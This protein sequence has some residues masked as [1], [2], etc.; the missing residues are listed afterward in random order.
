MPRRRMIRN[1]RQDASVLPEFIFDTS[2]D[3]AIAI[4]TQDPMPVGLRFADNPSIDPFGRLRVSN[5]FTIFDSK[6]L[7]DKNPLTWDEDIDN[8]SGNATSTHSPTNAAVTMHVDAGDTIIRQTFQHFNYQ[9]GK[10]QLTFLTFNFKGTDADT[11]KR[12][13]LFDED[14]GMFLMLN[15]ANLYFGIRKAGADTEIAQA[16]WNIDRLDGTGDSGITLD[17][18][19]VQILVIDYEWLG[20]GRVRFGFVINGLIYYCHV[21]NHANIVQSVYTS[22]PNHPIRYE[23]TS[24][25]GIGNLDHICS[26]VISEGGENPKGK[27]FAADT[28]ITFVGLATAGVE[29]GMIAIR[30]R[31]AFHDL[32]TIIEDF[33]TYST[34]N[35]AHYATLWL[36]PTLSAGSWTFANYNAT[37]SGLEIAYGNGTQVIS[38]GIKLHT[39][40]VEGGTGAIQNES[41]IRNLGHS[42]AGVNDIIAIGIR[43]FTNNQSCSAVINWREL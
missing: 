14:N 6:Q 12:V 42:I 43:P 27:T 41:N 23:I 4:S 30:L 22:S 16:D 3:R 31:A 11:A 40:V 17:V 8:V 33:L 1:I 34:S 20:V 25:N 36:N 35:G 39:H 24:G 7:Y 32:S 21:A 26:T 5:P 10:G 19:D 13:G 2:R 37:Y 29:Y 38:G 9:P 18:N 28:G 15:A